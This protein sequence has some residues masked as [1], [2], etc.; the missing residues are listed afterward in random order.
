MLKYHIQTVRVGSTTTNAITFSSIPQGYNDLLV[1]TSLR[2]TGTTN[3]WTNAFIRPNGVTSNLTTRAL[4]GWGSNNVGSF[5]DTYIYHETVGGGSTANTF[6]NSSIYISNYAGA[7]AKPISVDTSTANN[8]NALNAIVA[9]L[10]NSTS[11]I[12]SLSIVAESGN[13]AQ[14]SSASLYGIKRGSDG[15]TEVASGGV[16]TTSGGYTIHTFNTSG[17]FVANRNLD[18]DVLV[19]AGGGGGGA[20]QG[21]GGGAGGYV[22]QSLPLSASSY[23]ITVGAGG[24]GA[25]VNTANSGASGSNSVFASITALGGGG[26][27]SGNANNALSGGSGG[28]GGAQTVFGSGAAGTSGQGFAGANATSSGSYSGGGGGAGEPGSTDGLQQGGDGLS[29]SITGTSVVRGGGGGGGGY[30]GNGGGGLG[31]DGGGGAG[32]TGYPN[33]GAAGTSNTG[34]GGGGG[35]SI[36]GVG[37]GAGGAGGS[38]VVIIRYLTPA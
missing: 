6:S 27:G 19:I 4:Y 12:T 11:A 5:S 10:W 25:T 16:I 37:N 8:G 34:S 15:K 36:P 1:V 30:P 17:T 28:G 33:A 29:S 9:G 7:T 21:G 32:S 2:D 35:G 18:A 31:G 20:N 23:A 13:F 22:A 14:Y 38:G 24:T 3:G 26:G